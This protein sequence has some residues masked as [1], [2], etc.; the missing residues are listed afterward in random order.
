MARVKVDI[1]NLQ[2]DDTP[3]AIPST[4]GRR[5]VDISQIKLD[6]QNDNSLAS[7][8]DTTVGGVVGGSVDAATD[9]LGNI[10]GTATGKEW[11]DVTPTPQL[12]VLRK[13]GWSGTTTPEKVG[14]AVEALMTSPTGK[15]AQLFGANLPAVAATTAISEANPVVSK[16]TGIPEQYLQAGE[17]LG[18]GAY[19]AAK[20]GYLGGKA[21]GVADIVGGAVANKTANVQSTIRDMVGDNS[22]RGVSTDILPESPVITPSK[23]AFANSQTLYKQGLEL[24]AKFDPKLGVDIAKKATSLK[25]TGFKGNLDASEKVYNR[26]LDRVALS[27]KGID[28]SD[29]DKLDKDLTRYTNELNAAGRRNDLAKNLNNLKYE[30]RDMVRNPEYLKGSPQGMQLHSEAVGE[31]HR[32]SKLRD[33]EKLIA[34]SQ[35]TTPKKSLQTAIKN[36]RANENKMRG[37]TAEE[38]AALA[39]AEKTGIGTGLIDLFGSRMINAIAGAAGGG[40]TGGWV[41]AAG[42]AIAGKAAGGAVANYTGKLQANRLN[43]LAGQAIMESKGGMQTALPE[44][45]FNVVQRVNKGRKEVPQILGKDVKPELKLLPDY[46]G[47]IAMPPEIVLQSTRQKLLSSPN[48]NDYPKVIN[49]SGNVRNMTP[50]ELNDYIINQQNLSPDITAK[51]R[52]AIQDRNISQKKQTQKDLF[53]A[54]FKTSEK[55][56]DLAQAKGEKYQR[57]EVGNALINSLFKDQSGAVPESVTLNPVI[58]KK[59]AD[60]QKQINEVQ[61]QIQRQLNNGGNP[62]WFGLPDKLQKLQKEY[63]KLNSKNATKLYFNNSKSFSD[64]L[65]K[66]QDSL[67]N[68]YGDKITVSFQESKLSSSSYLEITNNE[69]GQSIKIRA[70]DHNLPRGYEASDIHIYPKVNGT[71][72]YYKAIDE[73]LSKLGLSDNQ[74]KEWLG[75][76]AENVKSLAKDQSGAVPEVNLPTLGLPKSPINAK[77]ASAPSGIKFSS[78]GKPTSLYTAIRNAGGVRD[79]GGDL[80]SMGHKDLTNPNGM[81]IDD[82]GNILH[83]Q[84]FFA[85]RPDTSEVLALLENSNG[86]REVFNPADMDRIFNA[87]ERKA[88]EQMNDPSYIEDQAYKAGIE[89]EG[90]ST[91]QIIQELEK[92]YKDQSGRINPALAAGGLA[93]GYKYLTSGEDNKDQKLKSPYAKPSKA[94]SPKRTP[95][96]L[97]IRP[98]KKQP[99]KPQAANDLFHRVIQQESGGKQFDKKGKPLKSKVGAIGIAQLMPKT[100]P[101]AAKLA[102]VPFDNK[103]YRTDANYNAK[104]GKAYLSHLLDKFDGNEVHAL[105]AYNWGKG[106]VRSWIKQGKPIAKVPQET[107]QYV[108]NILGAKR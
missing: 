94:Q 7:L 12:D 19:G 14:A 2:L 20:G 76:K 10:Y 62:N 74:A 67:E 96:R 35:T 18:G 79:S 29:F 66:A 50:E 64:N 4:T 104:L 101:E 75:K 98:E 92:F 6:N 99:A 81:S 39:Q 59:R 55:A 72:E 38:K 1:N 95:L 24:G 84:G 53:D 21:K 44:D 97:D 82:L 106:N 30:I 103:K 8:A 40:A 15:V 54:A 28:L 27:K 23:D 102:G 100:A 60:L 17:L 13:K 89:T 86:G 31:W 68:K 3:V 93:A 46:S 26:I 87:M 51:E 105:M 33:M 32:A 78:S 37:Y 61:S 63:D 34:K 73:S 41:G 36:F 42:G 90:K 58:N 45:V 69:T 70:S 85:N 47:S 43:K 91:K 9:I 108:L 5:K 57:G 22:A 65:R 77:S 83:E 16:V 49:R 56:K 48:P 107:K 71:Q 11:K 25:E 80:K 52:A 88:I